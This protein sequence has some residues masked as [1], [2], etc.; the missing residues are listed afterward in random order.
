M[1]ELNGKRCVL[2][3]GIDRVSDDG[4]GRRKYMKEECAKKKIGILFFDPCEKPNGL[5]SEIGVEKTKCRE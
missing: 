4:V 1:N 5:G 3:G 2:S